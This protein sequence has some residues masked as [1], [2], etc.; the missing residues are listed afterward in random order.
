ML[1]PPPALALSTPLPGCSEAEACGVPGAAKAVP[2]P[3]VRGAGWRP[4]STGQ[5]WGA[6]QCVRACCVRP[7]C[8]AAWSQGGRCVLLSCPAPG[9]CHLSPTRLATPLA[10]GQLWQLGQQDRGERRMKR[11][12]EGDV[13]KMEKAQPY[14]NREDP[15][16]DTHAAPDPPA[17]GPAPPV[18]VANPL[19]LSLTVNRK[20]SLSTSGSTELSDP[21]LA[22]QNPTPSTGMVTTVTSNSSWSSTR[23]LE[24]TTPT[25]HTPSAPTQAVRELV[26]SAGNSVEITLPRSEV[27]LNAFVLPEPPKGTEYVFDWRLITHPHDYSGEMEGKHSRILKLSK[28]TLGLY[29]FKVLVDGEGA[30]GEGYV[31]VTVKPEPRVNKP[32]VAVVSPRFQEISLPT[33]STVIDGSREYRGPGVWCP[34]SSAWF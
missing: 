12:E 28:L 20:G 32:P 2:W 11:S 26:V 4:L 31:N 19:T 6:V 24:P 30:H 14:V 34:V 9:R 25:S 33:S 22:A 13:G 10:R 27:Q 29:E 16:S 18:T 17:S 23:T 3:G 21:K 1:T 5:T 15:T 7:D 8:S